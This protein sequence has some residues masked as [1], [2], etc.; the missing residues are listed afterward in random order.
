MTE[1]SVAVQQSIA[2]F[3]AQAPKLRG[4]ALLDMDVRPNTTTQREIMQQVY[5][6][7]K[8]S[9]MHKLTLSKRHAS[10]PTGVPGRVLSSWRRLQEAR[11]CRMEHGG[12]QPAGGCWQTCA[13]SSHHKFPLRTVNTILEMV[14]AEGS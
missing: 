10:G 4:S 1:A 8:G 2:A 6:S 9:R 7:I 3:A 14:V 11:R 5:A 12:L 13:L